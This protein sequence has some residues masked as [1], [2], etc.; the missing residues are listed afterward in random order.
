SELGSELTSFAGSKLGSEL[1]SLGGSELGLASYRG[2]GNN[3]RDAGAASYGGAHNRVGYANPGQARQIKCYNCNDIGHLERNCTQPKRP[4]NS[5]CIKDKMLL[6]QAQEN[7]VELDEEQLLII[8]GGQDNDVDE[9]VNHAGFQ[10][11]RR[12]TSGSALP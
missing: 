5:E 12:T 7:R 6:M 1:T 2:Q 8:A 11:I 3:T 9:D 4:Q 10:D